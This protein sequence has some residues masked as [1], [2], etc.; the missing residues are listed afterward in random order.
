M[1]L[2]LFFHKIENVIELKLLKNHRNLKL[3]M[4]YFGEQYGLLFDIGI[5]L[6]IQKKIDFKWEGI[7]LKKGRIFFLM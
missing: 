7:N 1:M 3:N 2:N 5:L 4:V 6:L